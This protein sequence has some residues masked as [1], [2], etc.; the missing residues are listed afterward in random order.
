MTP[1]P[2]LLSSTSQ[3]QAVCE[4]ATAALFVMDARQHCVYMNAAAEALT[5]YTL[6][7]VQGAPLHDFVHH[8]HPDG[9]PYP[10][11]D[12]PID[13]AAPQN[14]Q[15]QG[16]E[17]FVH[18]SGRFYPVAFTASPIRRDGQVVGTVIEVRDR[19]LE[20]AREAEDRAMRE[21]A[22]TMLVEL[23]LDRMVQHVTDTATRLCGAEFGAFFYNTVG[24][25]GEA[26]MLYALSGV[27][28]EHFSKF[29]HPRA[30]PLFGPTFRG[31]GT[32]RIDD[33]PA[34]P[35]YGRWAP[36]HGM[37]AGHLPVRSYLA[38][39][40]KSDRDEV[41]GGLF[42]GHATPG[43]FQARHERVLESIAAQAAVGMS[44]LR[45]IQ[46]LEREARAKERLY[47]EAEAASHMKDQ[48]LATISHELRTPLTS[49]LGWS[50]MLAS[51]RLA[52]DMAARAVQT[53][54]R[55]ARAQAQ[56]I[57]DLLDIA[58]VVS[59]KLHLDVRRIAVAAPVEA[60][61]DAVRP[62]AIA[63]GVALV[64]DLPADAGEIDADP[65]RLQ[66]V[67][68]NLVAN[69][70]K[71]TDR[72]GRVEVSL[73]RGEGH[74][75][76]RVADT[77]RGIALDFLP[78]VFERFTQVDASSTR[79]HGGLGLGLAIVRHLVEMHGGEVT[80]SSAG[81]G[82]GA[83]FTVRLPF[84]AA[85]AR[86][87]PALDAAGAT[88]VAARS[89]ED[90]A[91][92]GCRVLLVE[93]DADSRMLLAEVLRGHG[94]TVQPMASAPE[95]LHGADAFEPTLVL[96]DIG[97]PGM[98]GY[99]FIRAW[100]RREAEAARPPVPAVALTAY[101]R[102]EDREQALAAGFQLHVAKPVQ[103]ADLVATLQALRRA[104]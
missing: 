36:H 95:A 17:V 53:I 61:V 43:V 57:D 19:T 82:E 20:L 38:V 59:G 15:E 80:A 62:A 58:R 91:L 23:D 37:P 10:L 71:F 75:E 6:A 94:A 4:N 12:C 97:M 26:F 86:G 102:D 3:L 54:D 84:A 60:A 52:P 11:A 77:G 85:P 73:R 41:L 5:G 93:D 101:A 32:I 42:L 24:E 13:R 22:E 87:L 89:A 98:D 83:A 66:Q 88:P 104:G 64:L 99:A 96:S 1:A 79:E 16:E 100:R 14:M 90:D 56:I 74:V 47:R 34:S 55:N 18:R 63:R 2:P 72:G 39:P 49:I 28:A 68:W 33:V 45:L 40:V 51:G 70:V 31:E 76:I 29:P 81:P 27:A 48:F 103:P 92:A 8:T 30:T 50:A 9:R 65:D 69:A 46:A 44:R 67:V 35:R 7:E 25:S 78:H 21:L